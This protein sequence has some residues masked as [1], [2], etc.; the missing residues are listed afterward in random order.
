IGI[1]VVAHRDDE[2]RVPAVEEIG[3]G[4][5]WRTG[6]T[7][8]AYDCKANRRRVDDNAG[9]AAG[10]AAVGRIGSHDRLRA[11]SFQ[12]GAEGVHASIACR[13]GVV[14]RQNGLA[15]GTGEV[16]GTRI[17]GGGVAVG[18]FGRHGEVAGNPGRGR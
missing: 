3:D 4:Q 17:T 14:G 2:V 7:V 8:V 9:L 1:V 5:F 15:V 10:D 18:V 12:C 6:Q 16:D 13:E 11:G